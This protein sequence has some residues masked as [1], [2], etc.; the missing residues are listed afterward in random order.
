MLA[1]QFI[2]DVEIALELLE[3]GQAF[4][5]GPALDPHRAPLIVVVGSASVGADAVDGRPPA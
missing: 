5:P 1:M 3:I 4:L 2:V